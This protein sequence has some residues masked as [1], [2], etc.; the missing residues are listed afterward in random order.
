[1]FIKL[2]GFGNCAGFLVSKGLFKVPE[3]SFSQLNSSNPDTKINSKQPQDPENI[4]TQDDVQDMENSMKKLLE[5]EE[6]GVVKII[7]KDDKK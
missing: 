5:L 7:R 2:T 3:N 1:M 4:Q 6:R